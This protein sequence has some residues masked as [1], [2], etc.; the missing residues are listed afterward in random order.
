MH[1]LALSTLLFQAV[2]SVALVLAVAADSFFPARRRT[3]DLA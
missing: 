1:I 3:A 2:A